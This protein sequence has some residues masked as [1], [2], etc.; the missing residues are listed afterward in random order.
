MNS[1]DG[2]NFL[3]KQLAIAENDLEKTKKYIEEL[4]NKKNSKSSKISL[5]M[6]CNDFLRDMDIKVK[7]DITNKIET[8]V[9]KLYQYV[10]QS[11]DRFVIKYETKAGVTNAY[12]LIETNKG[13]KSF[14]IDPMDSDGGGKIDVISL[15][16]RIATLLYFTPRIER[17]LVLD[18]PLVMIS[19]SS[20]SSD[21]KSR[22][23][24]F[25]KTI[26][27]E[28]KIQIIIVTHDSELMDVAD[29]NFKVS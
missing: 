19:N 27:R 21:Y 26:S 1:L 28:H 11:Q 15:G 20:S 10:F 14:L 17:I 12:F 6:G 7:T 23:A 18:E 29:K 16:L 25:L 8:L 5:F 13:G 24:E 9:T 4:R 2:L 22:A 3:E